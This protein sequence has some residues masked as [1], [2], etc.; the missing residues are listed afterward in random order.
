MSGCVSYVLVYGGLKCVKQVWGG[1]EGLR[2]TGGEGAEAKGL[3][4]RV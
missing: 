3:G 4:L 2:V 1:L